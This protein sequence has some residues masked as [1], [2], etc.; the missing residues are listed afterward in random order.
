[1]TTNDLYLTKY[2][3]KLKR[4]LPQMERAIRDGEVHRATA[5]GEQAYKEL[6]K[7][8][9]RLNKIIFANQEF[10]YVLSKQDEVKP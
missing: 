3:R 8:L 1:M 2:F 7:T 9:F 10:K 5:L 4:K 6:E